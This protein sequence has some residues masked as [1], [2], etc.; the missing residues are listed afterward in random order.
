MALC[1]AWKRSRIAQLISEIRNSTIFSVGSFKVDARLIHFIV[2]RFEQFNTNLESAIG[3][4][5]G[6]FSSISIQ[7]V[8]AVMISHGGGNNVL[9]LERH[10]KEGPGFIFQIYAGVHTAEHEVVALA[11]VARY[12]QHVSD[13]AASLDATWGWL[14]LNYAGGD[15]D[16]LASYG[17]TNIK[18]MRA[19]SKA[20]DPNA[21][22]QTL[23]R[24]GFKIP[25]QRH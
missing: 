1:L 18:R 14:F 10:A 25:Q 21:V 5:S 2:E 23:R 20:Y 3:S 19:A 15:Q 16:V 22:F 6:M 11:E 24:S 17:E 4:E 13:Y 7:P 8:T 12:F 9:G